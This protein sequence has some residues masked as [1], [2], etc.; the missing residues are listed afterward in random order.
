MYDVTVDYLDIISVTRL[1]IPNEEAI[2]NTSDL[3]VKNYMYNYMM[4]IEVS[5]INGL[6]V[7]NPKHDT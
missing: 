4:Q 2:F 5:A 3:F 7:V 6:S 1:Q